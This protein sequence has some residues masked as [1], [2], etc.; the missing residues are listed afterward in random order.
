VTPYINGGLSTHSDVCKMKQFKCTAHDVYCNFKG[1]KSEL[2][3]HQ[4]T[5]IHLAQRDVLLPVIEDLTKSFE[6]KN[7]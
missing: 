5:C 6:K 7:K 3:K 4:P 2:L 1:S